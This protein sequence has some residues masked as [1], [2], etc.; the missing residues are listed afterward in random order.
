MEDRNEYTPKQMADFKLQEFAKALE[1]VDWRPISL[2]LHPA[3]PSNALV[4][5]PR[6][7]VKVSYGEVTFRAQGEDFFVSTSNMQILI[8][9]IVEIKA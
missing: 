2:N 7:N 9:A 1:R 4:G 5:T 6:G 8:H 3:L